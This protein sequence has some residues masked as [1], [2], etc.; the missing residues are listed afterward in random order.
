MISCVNHPTVD[1]TE[2]RPTRTNTAVRSADER[3]IS[4]VDS[5]PTSDVYTKN[6][7]RHTPVRSVEQS[8]ALNLRE[9]TARI[10]V[11]EAVL[12]TRKSASQNSM[13]SELR[14]RV[15]CVARRSGFILPTRKGTFAPSVFET[16]T[17]GTH[18]DRV[19]KTTHGGTAENALSTVVFAEPPLNDTPVT[20]RRLL[21]VARTVGEHGSQRNSAGR[22]T[23]TGRVAETNPTAKG[24]LGFE[25]RHSN[26]MDISV[27]FVASHVTRLDEIQTSI[28]S[29]PFGGSPTHANTRQKTLTSS[30]T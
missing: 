24:G 17:G 14:Q 16:K 22:D 30:K 11:D 8:F 10:S 13:G 2:V 4:A 26:V 27:R 3:S 9:N 6:A 25:K 21:S 12:Q 18:H 28:T 1:V 20:L 19:A 5:T 7:L 23:R 15:R 29:S